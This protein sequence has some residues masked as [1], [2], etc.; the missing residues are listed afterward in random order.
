MN[1]VT[2]IS[3]TTLTGLY[4]E[5]FILAAYELLLGRPVDEAGAIYYLGRL[6]AGYSK[7][8]ILQQLRASPEAQQH[9]HG[10][11]GLDKVLD[12]YRLSQRAIVG[13]LFRRWWKLEADGPAERL[14]RIMINELACIRQQLQ[15]GIAQAVTIAA[16]RNS[17]GYRQP[18]HGK[19]K[20]AE[21]LTPKAREMFD[22]LVS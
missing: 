17:H 4:D 1:A 12:R 2:V 8:S 20:I 16:M 15:E 19:R 7:L 13:T 10:I 5:D 6:R 3:V 21:Q 11:L 18:D 9:A 22:R 14:Q